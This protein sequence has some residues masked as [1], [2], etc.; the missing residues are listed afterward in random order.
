[1]N[2]KFYLCLGLI[3][4]VALL[5]R[6]LVGFELA[7]ANNGLNSVVVPSMQTDMATYW[8][9][10]GRIVAGAFRDEFYYQPFYYAIFLP[11]IR[12]LL[13]D[14]IFSVIVIQALLGGVTVLLTGL[15]GSRLWNR[16]AGIVSAILAGLSQMLILYTPYLLIEILQSFWVIL[17]LYLALRAIE[18]RDKLDWSLCAVALGCSILTRGNSWFFLPGLLV[19]AVYSLMPH[20]GKI[21]YKVLYGFCVVVFFTMLSV[22]P[23]LPFMIRNSQLRGELTGPSTAGGTVLALGNTPEAPPGGRDPGLPA[24]PMEY[25]PTWSAWMAEVSTVSVPRRIWQW[26]YE[27][28]GA[29]LELTFR[30]L[31]LFWDYREIPNNVSLA[32]EGRQSTIFRF[33][34]SIMPTGVIV[35]LAI[36]G[37]LVSLIK[38]IRKRSRWDLLL[39]IYMI[40]A[41]WGA[42]ALFYIL[43]RFR[44]PIIPVLAIFAG[45]FL[46]WFWECYRQRSVLIIG[47]SALIFGVFISFSAYDLYRS[48]LESIIVGWVRPDGVRVQIAPGRMMYLDNGPMT[49]GGWEFIEFKLGMSVTKQFADTASKNPKYREAEITLAS[50]DAGSAMISLNGQIYDFVFTRPGLTSHTYVLPENSPTQITVKVISSENPVLFIIDRQRDYGRTKINDELFAGEMVCRLFHSDRSIENSAEPNRT[51]NESVKFNQELSLR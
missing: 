9:I 30:K 34:G 41:F 7:F 48:N 44:V 5:L 33:A 1:M 10:S 11:L 21:R 6:L 36:A 8:E 15:C 45:I 26:F 51:D 38:V 18:R 3:A 22:L 31:L 27:E 24:G 39:P 42:T 29:V 20:K 17:I 25:P 32:F 47:G 43:A 49:F 23:Q 12:W 40:M 14:S 19:A 46:V 28:P 35:A 13:G 2:R 50:E 16:S 4:I 37:M